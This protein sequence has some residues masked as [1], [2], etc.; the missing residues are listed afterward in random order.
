LL[1]GHPVTAAGRT[2][3]ADLADPEAKV[4]LEVD[5]WTKY[6]T[7]ASEVR[8]QLEYERGRQALIEAQGWPVRRWAPSDGRDHVI[9]VVTQ[10]RRD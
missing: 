6:G 4:V 9:S 7:T 3:R 5:G 1:V 8:R 2:V 10:A